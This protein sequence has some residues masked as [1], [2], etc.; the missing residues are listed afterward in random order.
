MIEWIIESREKDRMFDTE[1][2]TLPGS[3]SY[4]GIALQTWARI[5]ANRENFANPLVTTDKRNRK[6]E[7]R[8]PEGVRWREREIEFRISSR[9]GPAGA[10][11]G[12]N[13]SRTMKSRN[14]LT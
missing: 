6:R 3:H 1:S 12:L 9:R 13:R 5:C 14:S 7:L 10:I 4:Q 2:D 11:L 8:I